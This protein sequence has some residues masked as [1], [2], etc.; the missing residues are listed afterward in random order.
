MDEETFNDLMVS[1]DAG[2]I[3]VTTAVENEQAG[4]LVG[5]HSQS[6]MSP[7][8]YGF[9]LSKANHTYQVS[10]RATHFAI[11]FLTVDDLAMAQRFGARSGEDTD[12]FRGLDVDPTEQGVP[13]LSALPNRLVVERITM[14]DD[15]GDHVAITARV[16][17]SETTGTF[18]P[19]RLSHIG[20]LPPGRDNDSRAIHL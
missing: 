4:C 19:L 8:Q 18:T 15:G 7:Q 2:L 1:A 16:I 11:H 3:V 20:D 12:K 5:F 14:L 13:L 10:L 9:W 6:S 17:S